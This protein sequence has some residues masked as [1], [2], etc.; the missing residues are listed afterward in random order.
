[1]R[2][3]T[4]LRTPG[5]KRKHGQHLRKSAS[6]LRGKLTKLTHL[7]LGSW[8]A[9]MAALGG[10]L[11]LEGQERLALHL[12]MHRDRDPGDLAVCQSEGPSVIWQ[13]LS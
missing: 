13:A 5:I 11:V 8:A 3:E 1:M 6:L 10:R 4:E 2:K 12:V 7:N 9:G